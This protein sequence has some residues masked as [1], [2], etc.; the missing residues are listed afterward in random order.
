MTYT[1]NPKKLMEN[2]HRITNSKGYFIFSHRLDLWKK[3]S[4]DSLLISLSGKW[5]N[6]YIS[7]PLLYLPKNK[8]FTDK[9]KIRICLLE[10]N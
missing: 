5:K 7:R 8:D 1:K 4:Y 2:I 6:I 9:I 10:K 3:Q